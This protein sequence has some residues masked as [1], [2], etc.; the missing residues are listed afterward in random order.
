MRASTFLQEV[1][2]LGIRTIAGVPDSTLKPFCD[3]V[4]LDGGREFQ[5]YVTANEGA[6]VGLATGIYL[7]QRR[8]CLIYLQNSGL[9]NLINPLASIAN[10]EVYGIPM[11]FVIGWRGEPGTPDEPQHVFQGKIT[12]ALLEVKIGRAHV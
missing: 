1:R 11:L 2:K 12:C 4:C 3:A 8:P 5:H 9:G 7:A 6:A 10:Q